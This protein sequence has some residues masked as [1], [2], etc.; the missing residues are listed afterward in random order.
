MEHGAWRIATVMHVEERKL[1][2]S[3]VPIWLSTLPFD[4]TAALVSTLFIEQGSVMDRCLG[5]HFVLPPASIFAFAAVAMIANVSIYDNKVLEPC[6]QRAMVR[7]DGRGR[8]VRAGGAAGV[9]LRPGAGHHR[10]LGIGL[11]LSVIGA[12]SFLS[13]LVIAAA[14]HV[15]SHGGRR[16]GWFGK[17]L[18]RSR[19][20]LFYWLL[21]GI[22]AANLVFYVLVATRYSYKQKHV[23]KA[24]R[25]GAEKN[26]GGDIECGT[27]VSA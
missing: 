22:C 18:S 14:D 9:L 1:V 15:S 7:A 17:D 27:T 10:S 11:Y 3:M 8:R 24:T 23:V 20:D 13:S 25:V 12:G 19:L 26:V 6:L 4:I 21:A 16:D 5:P 2:V